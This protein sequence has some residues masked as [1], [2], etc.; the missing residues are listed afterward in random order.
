MTSNPKRDDL[1]GNE[2][3]VVRLWIIQKRLSL[4]AVRQPEQTNL[5]FVIRGALI[6]SLAWLVVWG[7]IFL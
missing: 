7:I 5:E 4:E 2:E 3:V 6:V 1:D